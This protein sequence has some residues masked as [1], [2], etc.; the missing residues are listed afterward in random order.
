M[1]NPHRSGPESTTDCLASHSA[2]LRMKR[3]KRPRDVTQM[4]KFGGIMG[5]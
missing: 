4:A 5:K 2:G 1:N 3:P